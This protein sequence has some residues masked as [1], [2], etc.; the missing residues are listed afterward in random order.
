MS[1]R[2]DG[3][4]TL[5]KGWI[6][7]S[8]CRSV[9][10]RQTQQ[11]E[12]Y[13]DDL[14]S[15]RKKPNRPSKGTEREGGKGGEE[16]E[17]GEKE[18]QTTGFSEEVWICEMVEMGGRQKARESESKKVVSSGLACWANGKEGG[19]VRA[20]QVPG[21]RGAAY[22]A[23]RSPRKC[24]HDWRPR[25]LPPRGACIAGGVGEAPQEEIGR[26]PP[27]AGSDERPMK[28]TRWAGFRTYGGDR[29]S[30]RTGLE[31]LKLALRC[32]AVARS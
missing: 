8:S 29:G 31:A 10:R 13:N 11:T 15:V 28:A 30:G 20:A 25:Y 2:A 3:R 23:L 12:E 1:K 4:A 18:E 19:A 26:T 17:R 9:H 7:S 21:R 24:S 16:E 5:E 27:F 6:E 22:L 32:M 14:Q